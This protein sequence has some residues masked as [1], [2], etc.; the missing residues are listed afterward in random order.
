MNTAY[1]VDSYINNSGKNLKHS[2]YS[3]RPIVKP[4]EKITERL[5]VLSSTNTLFNNMVPVPLV[6]IVPI[7]K[8]KLNIL[9]IFFYQ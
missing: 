6:H 5:M 2:K 1:N 8:L 3:N 4:C 9:Y 7:R